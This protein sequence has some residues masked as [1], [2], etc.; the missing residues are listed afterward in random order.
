[1]TAALAEVS[2][3]LISR[4]KLIEI[5]VESSRTVDAYREAVSIANL[6]YESGMSSYFEVLDAMQQ[7]FP[8]EQRL[9]RVR[10]DELNAVVE[11][12]AALGGGWQVE[13]ADA[14]STR[15]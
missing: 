14:A 4:Q 15:P 5:R 11:L 3:A 1:V 7:L 8:A 6:R 13:E 9:A 10:R 2:T 12:Y